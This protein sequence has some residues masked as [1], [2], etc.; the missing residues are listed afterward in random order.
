MRLQREAS[1]QPSQCVLST[2]TAPSWKVSRDS[3]TT[4]AFA[5]SVRPSVSVQT[6]YTQARSHRVAVVTSASTS[7]T[8]I[9]GVGSMVAATLTT[10]P[11]H[12]EQVQYWTVIVMPLTWIRTV[13]IK[14][15]EM[16][17]PAT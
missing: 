14:R 12:V 8:V 15:V 2:L 7:G 5:D 17:R 1:S 11:T 10:T 4:G 16:T 3:A 6:W 13:A 9:D